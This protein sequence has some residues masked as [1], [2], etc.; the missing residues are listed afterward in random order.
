MGCSRMDMYIG[1]YYSI[2]AEKKLTPA[3]CNIKTLAFTIM[4]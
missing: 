1:K 4:V 2:S 3:R